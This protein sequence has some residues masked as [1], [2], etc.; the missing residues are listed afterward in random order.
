MKIIQSY[1]QKSDNDHLSFYT[2]MLNYLIL[3]KNYGKVTMYC[4]KKTYNTVIKHIPYDEIVIMENVY[5]NSLLYK[6]FVIE[7]QHEKFIYVDPELIFFENSFNMFFENK[8][9]LLIQNVNPA[10]ILGTNYCVKKNKD[11]LNKNICNV[12]NYDGSYFSTNIVGMTVDFKNKYISNVKKVLNN[13]NFKGMFNNEYDS[14]ILEELIIYL[15]YLQNKYKVVEIMSQSDIILGEEY[16]AN[17][18]KFIKL[19][20]ITYKSRYIELLKNKIRNNFI[21][22]Y[23]IVDLFEKNINI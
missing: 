20:N 21:S 22:D 18:H 15:T 13:T 10:D 5:S 7:Q 3:K 8:C 1:I 6:I 4:D 23:Y 9:D 14:L 19:N 11:F 17:K 2:F 16:C 12:N